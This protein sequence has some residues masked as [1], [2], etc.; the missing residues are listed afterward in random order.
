[1]NKEKHKTA[2]LDQRA[3]DLIASLRGFS[4]SNGR[5]SFLRNTKTLDTLLDKAL[6]KL[7][8]D[9]RNLE[10]LIMKNWREIVGTHFSHRVSPQTIR[11]DNVLVILAKNAMIKSELIFKEK[12]IF[13]KIRSIPGC[14]A[15]KAID[16]KIG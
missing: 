3:L 2:I 6:K 7:V 14:E 1:M 13:A 16:I 8:P 12:E 5:R 11:Q 4:G 15:I 10:E 9:A